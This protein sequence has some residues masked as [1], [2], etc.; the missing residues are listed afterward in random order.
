MGS[1]H[2]RNL[3]SLTIVV[4]LLTSASPSID[5]VRLAAS[6]STLCSGRVEIYY[7]NTWGTVCDDR[8]DLNDA[9]VV[10]RQLGCDTALNAPQLAH[11]G[12]GTGQIWLD[13]VACSGS[14]RSLTECGHNGFGTHNCNH[15]EDAGVICS[16]AVRL[17]ASG[18]T[19]C[20]GRVE[21]YYNNTWGTVC[22]DRWDLNDAEVVCRQLDCGTAVNA[23]QSAH[24]GEGT[25]QI[26]LDEVACSGSERSLTECGHNGF[27]THNCNHS[28]DAG[29][30]CSDPVRLAASGSTL[31]SGRVEIYY[32]NTWG[33]IC[34]DR[35]DL[36]DAEVVCRQLDCGTAVNAI[37]SAHFGEGTG[38]IWLDEV[39][40]SGSERSLTECGHNG[41]GT[42]NCNHSE[43]AGVICSDGV[44]LS[45]SGSTLCSGRVEIYHSN[46]WGTICDDRWDLNDAEVVCR[47]LDCGTAL[48]ATQSAHFGEGTGQIWLDEVACSGSER[49]LT[50]CRHNGFGTHNCIHSED[51]SVICSGP[52]RLVGSGSTLCSGR[53]EIYYNNTWGTICDDRWGLNDAEV[54]CRQLGCGAAI[55]A[56]HSA[57]FGEGTGQIWL[58]EVA[59][60]G[61]ERSLTECGHSG[62]GTHKCGHDEDAGVICSVPLS[63]VVYLVTSGVLLLLLLL[64]LLLVVC[65]FHRRRQQINQ[66]GSAIVNQMNIKNSSEDDED[67]RFYVNI[68]PFNT[69]RKQKEKVGGTKEEDDDDGYEMLDTKNNYTVYGDLFGTGQDKREE[70]DDVKSSD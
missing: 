20:S 11:F 61:S 50:E 58:D 56:T 15:S 14:E 41:F 24:F 67:N 23:I 16:D 68:E 27:G 70:E 5:P 33:T 3:F 49:S 10:C 22:D 4:L 30:I 60:S 13:E 26:W 43:D 9:E 63:L 62:F 52:V 35:W 44:R 53:V 45:G 1:T 18:S 32:N 31:C 38:Q 59:C 54:V 17:A 51:A 34:D 39:A 57:H 42:H 65:V 7:N 47:Q 64:L 6:G 66:P 28:E 12:E 36:N 2:H 29:V 55:N 19:L 25:G 48:N 40:C 69:K 46:T 37:Q 8:W 21:I